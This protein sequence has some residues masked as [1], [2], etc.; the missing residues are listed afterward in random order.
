MNTQAANGNG[1]LLY[2]ILGILGTAITGSGSAW[3]T[4]MHTLV[5]IHGE[6]IAVLESQLGYQKQQL[7]R[8]DDK[9]DRLL[10]LEKGQR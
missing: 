8:M 2:W 3:L 10:Q 4:S 6:K 5:R 9:L 1:K 7:Q